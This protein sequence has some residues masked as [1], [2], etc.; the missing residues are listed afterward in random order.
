MA[1]FKKLVGERIYLSPVSNDDAEIFTT[2]LNDFQVTDYIVRSSAVTT[3]E[4]EKEWVSDITSNIKYTMSIVLLENDQVIGNTGL[5]HVNHINRT[6]TLGIMIGEEDYRGNG[7]GAEAIELLLDYAFNYL[8]LNNV[9]LALLSCN[10]RARKCYTKVGFKEYGRRRMCAYVNGK[11]Y[12]NIFMDILA[13]E[14]NERK[15]GAIK[16]K[17]VR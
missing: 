9:E 16:N 1:H 6:A 2:W 12:D 10:E 7:Y 8:N 5:M 14:F 3:L 11:Y 17:N 13:S 4:A 15:T